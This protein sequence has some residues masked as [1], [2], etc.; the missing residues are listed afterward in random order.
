M[1]RLQFL[2]TIWPVVT[3]VVTFLWRAPS[4]ESFMLLPRLS[5]FRKML[6]ASGF[7]GPKMLEAIGGI[8]LGARGIKS[9]TEEHVAALPEDIRA[10]LPH[11]YL[12]KPVRTISGLTPAVL[13]PP[14]DSGDGQ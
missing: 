6:A 3:L 10:S 13:P 11:M 2:A 12:E 14:V 7:D 1:S 4:P 8:V 5:S 9:P